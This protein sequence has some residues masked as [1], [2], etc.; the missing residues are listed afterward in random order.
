MGK[1]WNKSINQLAAGGVEW[2]EVTSLKDLAKIKTVEE[3]MPKPAENQTFSRDPTIWENEYRIIEECL[4]MDY[5]IC[6][7]CMMAWISRESYKNHRKKNPDFAL[8]MDRARQFPKML[9]RTAV[10]RRIRQWDAKTALEYL[11]LRDRR[12]KTEPIPEDWEDFEDNAQVVQF[13]SVPS[14]KWVD[15]TTNPDSQT[16]IK[17]K[18]VWVWYV[19]SSEM[20]EGETHQKQTP[21]ENE[22]EALKRLGL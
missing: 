15:N 4:K 9:A 2:E 5:T 8:R 20:S 13:I 3:L 11:K 17:Q 16:D 14:N 21:W 10:Q 18:S 1:K 7:A 6:D 19:S 12:Y 22:E